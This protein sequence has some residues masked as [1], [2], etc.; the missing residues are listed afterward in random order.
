MATQA[1]STAK[2]VS[3][4]ASVRDIT[5]EAW[6]LI[7]ISV[8]VVAF[9]VAMFATYGHTMDNYALTVLAVFAIGFTVCATFIAMT[10][11]A[12]AVRNRALTATIRAWSKYA[13]ERHDKDGETIDILNDL[14]RESA[15][16]RA[17]LRND[18]ES[19]RASLAVVTV[20]RDALRQEHDLIANKNKRNYARGARTFIVEFRAPFYLDDR[21]SVETYID[22]QRV[23]RGYGANRSEA[24]REAV[25][26][27]SHLLESRALALA[28]FQSTLT[29]AGAEM[30][31]DPY[32]NR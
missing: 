28:P 16:E 18:L 31:L 22:G 8:A 27:M 15:T 12:D 4:R 29:R 30:F 10:E 19:A 23:G 1:P 7:G 25:S 21:Y 9:I 20:E 17:T 26:E 14:R 6:A 2:A 5:R 32:R 11:T 24:Y 13:T 3:A